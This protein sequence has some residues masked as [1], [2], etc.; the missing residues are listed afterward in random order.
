ME[1][2]IS[3][4]SAWLGPRWL[5]SILASMALVAITTAFLFE[6]QICLK[7]QHLIFAYLLPMTLVAIRYGSAPATLVSIAGALSAVYFLYPPKFSLYLTPLHIG[8][9]T[10]FCTLAIAASQI[11]AAL[12]EDLSGRTRQ[13]QLV[14]QKSA[15]PSRG[16]QRASAADDVR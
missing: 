5:L 10:F 13:K 12:S 16:V 14:S 11:V 6:I 7:P 8:E 2:A 1:S 15:M 4:L 3:R 9:V